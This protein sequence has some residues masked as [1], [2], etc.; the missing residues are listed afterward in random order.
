M[1]LENDRLF[2]REALA[3]L[4][5]YLLSPELYRPLRTRSEGG[6]HLPQ[7]TIG[8]LMLSRSRLQALELAGR[9]EPGLAEIS[10]QID[11]IRR[12]WR[13]NWGLKAG[14]EYLSRIN[15][16]QQFIRELSTDVR[17]RSPVYA[18]EVRVRA[19][20]HLLRSEVIDL[21]AAQEEQLAMLDQILRGLT[22]P[23]PFVWE[24]DLAAGFGREDFWFLYV[25]FP[26]EAR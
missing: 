2:L 15:L 4:R 3:D 10:A 5:D 6:I 9:P 12:E 20:L 23:G 24:S 13:T 19:I 18:A 21:P 22:Q 26:G 25:S 7:L 11:E 16:W 17:R 14:R 1:A 8:S